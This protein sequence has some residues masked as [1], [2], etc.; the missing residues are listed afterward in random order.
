MMR[1]TLKHGNGPIKFGMIRI[2]NG[3]SIALLKWDQHSILAEIIGIQLIFTDFIKRHMDFEKVGQPAFSA[4]K[5]VEILPFLLG[6]RRRR[7]EPITKSALRKRSLY[8]F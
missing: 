2:L 6:E 5:G 4:Y 7:D 3:I 8:C 1:V